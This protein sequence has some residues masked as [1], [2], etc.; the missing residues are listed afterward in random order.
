MLQSYKQM[1]KKFL[2][3]II[4]WYVAAILAVGLLAYFLISPFLIQSL[5]PQYEIVN[6][7]LNIAVCTDLAPGTPS[8]VFLPVSCSTVNKSQTLACI[9][10][11]TNYIAPSKPSNDETLICP[12]LVSANDSTGIKNSALAVLP[13]TEF[14]LQIILS[15]AILA[16]VLIAYL[17]VFL[18]TNKIRR[19]KL[20]K[21][22]G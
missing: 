1:F 22:E 7:H 15:L 11:N 9:Y 5:F 10:D 21:L 14:Q 12:M 8:K 3:N 13:I 20:V 16:T 17:A 18:V 4:V 2:K 6:K 19:K